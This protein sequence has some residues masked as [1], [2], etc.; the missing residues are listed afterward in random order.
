MGDLSMSKLLNRNRGKSDDVDL[1]PSNLNL[2][3]K[4][5]STSKP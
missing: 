2:M 3:A 1:I 5:I 4:Q